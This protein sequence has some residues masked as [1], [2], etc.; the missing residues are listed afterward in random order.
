M[1]TMNDTTNERNIPHIILTNMTTAAELIAGV[2][3]NV[4]E[5]EVWLRTGQNFTF[6][7]EITSGSHLEVK[8]AF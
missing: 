4:Y 7:I 1:Q 8:K 5:N 2:E 3:R 6:R